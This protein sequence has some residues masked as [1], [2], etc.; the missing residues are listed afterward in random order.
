MHSP[1]SLR[2]LAPPVLALLSA[3][4]TEQAFAQDQPRP[5]Q[6]QPAGTDAD[7]RRDM[8]N[9]MRQLEQENRELREQVGKVAETQR[10][11]MKDAQE[12]GLLTLEGGQPR[13]TT[14]E[15]FDTN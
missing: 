15:F 9:R 1:R 2:L 10:A 12:R 14:P 11:V 13:L 6:Q 8:E 4:V 7:W 3:A 5:P